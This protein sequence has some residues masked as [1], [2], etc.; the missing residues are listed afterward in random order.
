MGSV[1]PFIYK[2]LG[3]SLN[4]TIL[5]TRPDLGYLDTL[6]VCVGGQKK[7]WHL[8]KEEVAL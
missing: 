2:Y 1:F 3:I 4:P 7:P 5:G 8:L 6:S